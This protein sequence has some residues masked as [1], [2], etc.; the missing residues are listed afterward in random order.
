MKFLITIIPTL[1]FLGCESKPTILSPDDA[2]LGIYNLEYIDIPLRPAG[3][4]HGVDFLDEMIGLIVGN[5][6]TI[7]GTTDGGI[8]WKV[9]DSTTGVLLKDVAILDY[10]TAVVVGQ[11]RILRTEDGGD[12]WGQV[13]TPDKQIDFWKVDFANERLG[14][15]VGGR[16]ILRTNDG[17]K[18]WQPQEYTVAKGNFLDITIVDS[19]VAYI[20]PLKG[21]IL[22]T[23]DGGKSWDFY[24]RP[25]GAG[26]TYAMD[27]S[28]DGW[29]L[30]GDNYIVTTKDSKTTWKTLQYS[31]ERIREIIMWADG[32]GIVFGAGNYSGGDFGHTMGS[33][34]YTTD[35][36]E[37]WQGT[38]QLNR[39]MQIESASFILQ[40][41]GYVVA[42]NVLIKITRQRG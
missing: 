3:L 23:T 10:Q 26:N 24:S 21:S 29:F 39:T 1:F 42:G 31:P 5:N 37:N 12:T 6:G 33:M 41:L 7:V 28:S 20:T 14:Y 35:A 25:E 8:S 22:H 17:G 19:N 4:Y 16:F 32:S 30:A 18:T 38:Y 34:F 40:Q 11:N 13:Y 9:L 15:A 36:G 2:A 27:V